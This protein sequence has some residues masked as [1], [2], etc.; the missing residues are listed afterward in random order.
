MDIQLLIDFL[1]THTQFVGIVTYFVV[2]MEAMAVIGVIIPGS[3]TMS[4][5][6][7]LIGANV[8]PAGSTFL[9]GICGAIS[10]DYLS[11]II[12]MHYKN[13]LH[14]V[15]PFKKHPSWLENSK[16]FFAKHGGKSVF[17]GRFV[18]PLRSMVPMVAGMLHMP[19]GKFLLA[20]IPSGSLWAVGY[21]F[22]GIIL[23]ALASELPPKLATEFILIGLGALL[24]ISILGW[25]IHRFA[26]VIYMLLD[27]FILRLWIFIKN[28]KM[29]SWFAKGLE[30][31]REP[32]NHRQLSLLF[33]AMLVFVLF[34]I[35]FFSVAHQGILTVLNLPLYHLLSSIRLPFLDYI[36]VVITSSSEVITLVC[37]GGLFLLWLIYKRYW[38]VA[39][40]WFLILFIISASILE[41]KSFIFSPRPGGA[42]NF[43]L[44][45]S[46]PSGH[47]AMSVAIFG[48]WAVI[49]ARDLKN[50][51]KRWIPYVVAISYIFLVAVSRLYLGAH[52]LTDVVGSFLF[53][54]FLVIVFT[55]SYRRR[56]VPY[57]NLRQCIFAS[58]VSF[59]VATIGYCA[60]ELPNQLKNYE[61]SWPQQTVPLIEVKNNITKEIPLYRLNRF[62][63]PVQ[64]FNIKWIG[65]LEDIKQSLLQKGWETQ[66]V[67]LNLPSAIKYFIG[68]SVINNLSLFPQLYHNKPTV[69]LMTKMTTDENAIFVL[70][71]WKSDIAI[72]GGTHPLWLGEIDIHKL[73]PKFLKIYNKK[74]KTKFVGATDEFAKY[75]SKNKFDWQ[76]FYTPRSEQPEE[77]KYL[78]WDGK[79]LLIEEN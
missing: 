55:I 6:G 27:K 56:H 72:T 38:Y 73:P 14:K 8:I 28:H 2:F 52:W 39:I 60:L 18:G 7:A 29:L 46:F 17:L 48:F 15:W 35:V 62:G 69:L 24:A 45:S 40:H 78:D 65:S 47:T 21:M 22:P 51:R 37:A 1:H 41:F 66:P 36:M 70:R 57:I 23:G 12:G 11:Y 79:S 58:A 67:Q 77:I 49:V 63:R 53:G 54:T 19:L 3:V 16:K 76:E 5:I 74:S 34:L 75:L 10:G 44:T 61:L 71:L 9:W 20:A 13:R 33:L 25:L 4:A 31:P 59:V 42:L 26:R 64:V 32:D 68:S 30:D 50:V 43:Q